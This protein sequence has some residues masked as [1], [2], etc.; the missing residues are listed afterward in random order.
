MGACRRETAIGAKTE[1]RG[2]PARSSQDGEFARP[3]AV[4]L[5]DDPTASV[6]VNS[7][8]H[9][10]CLSQTVCMTFSTIL[11]LAGPKNWC[12][13]VLTQIPPAV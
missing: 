1:E 6:L 11:A 5:D 4:L 13:A 2:G 8:L 12:V 9:C 7:A 3:P 10:C